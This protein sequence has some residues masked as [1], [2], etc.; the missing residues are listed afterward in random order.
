M[1]LIKR[2]YFDILFTKQVNKNL[3]LKVILYVQ[4]FEVDFSSKKNTDLIKRNINTH[5]RILEKLKNYFYKYTKNDIKN[6][7]TNERY[8]AA[9]FIQKKFNDTQNITFY[10]ILKRGVDLWLLNTKISLSES[11]C[12]TREIFSFKNANYNTEREA[13]H[14]SIDDFTSMKIENG[15]IKKNRNGNEFLCKKRHKE[16]GDNLH[17]VEIPEKIKKALTKSQ[18]GR[19]RFEHIDRYRYYNTI[20]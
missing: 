12:E 18:K 14:V 15:A 17:N 3:S 8:E 7:L 2:F 20:K 6:N 16:N 4:E 9:N 10:K 1:V 5:P 11:E 13:G 19:I